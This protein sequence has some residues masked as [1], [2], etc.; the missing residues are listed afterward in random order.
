MCLRYV[1]SNAPQRDQVTALD[2]D[3][4]AD[5]DQQRAAVP[6]H[7]PKPVDRVCMMMKRRIDHRPRHRTVLG[8]HDARHAG[9]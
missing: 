6:E 3:V 2:S 5:L 8:M 4:T 1:A 7:L 9:S